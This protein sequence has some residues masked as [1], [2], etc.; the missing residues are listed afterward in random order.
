MAASLFTDVHHYI[1]A[2]QSGLLGQQMAMQVISQA[3]KPLEH[4]L[5]IS[6]DDDSEPRYSSFCVRPVDAFA[7][8]LSVRHYSQYE[9]QTKIDEMTLPG[10]DNAQIEQL[11]DSAFNS[12]YEA[13]WI[14]GGDGIEQRCKIEIT[15]R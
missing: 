9:W 12:G 13:V 10:Y 8:G 4:V 7:W 15:S 11:T 5:C 3:E 2:R 1:A 6:I 14:V